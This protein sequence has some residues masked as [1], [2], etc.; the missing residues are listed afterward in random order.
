MD[1]SAADI[2]LLGVL[3]KRSRLAKAV[4]IFFALKAL[5]LAFV[6]VW[7]GVEAYQGSCSVGGDDPMQWPALLL[8]QGRVFW[9]VLLALNAFICGSN[10]VFFRVQHQTDMLVLKLVDQASGYPTPR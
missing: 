3:R 1:L 9:T 6:A 8:Q 7:F 5:L 4:E 10:C 2:K